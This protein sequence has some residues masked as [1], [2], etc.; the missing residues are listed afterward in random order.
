MTNTVIVKQNYKS[1]PTLAKLFSDLKINQ[2]QFAFVHA[3][4]AAKENIKDVMPRMS[5]VAP[6]AKK[7]LQ[8][9]IDNN[10]KVMIE[11]MPPCTL[12]GYER[13]C[14]ELQIPDTEI[15]G[16]NQFDPDYGKTRKTLGKVKFSACKSCRYCRVC[17]GPWKEYP[18]LYGNAEFDQH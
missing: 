3:V 17:E 18:I 1:L 5:D 6:Y 4:G 2:F 14:S 15:R 7:G 10:I 12:E 13:Y 8:I 9:G 11:A 16:M